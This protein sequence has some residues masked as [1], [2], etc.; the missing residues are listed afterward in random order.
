[1]NWLTQQWQY[2]LDH[3]PETLTPAQMAALDKA[4]GLTK[5]G[6]AEIVQSWL[7]LVIV[8]D[9]QPGMPRLEDYLATVGRIRLIL[10][11]YRQMM[12]TEA[13]AAAARRIYKKVRSNYHPFAASSVD[14]VV[15]LASDETSDEQ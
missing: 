11:L 2:F 9:Y 13:G 14:A 1:M 10:P 12:K 7:R 8:H 3:M 15:D 6:N 5:S 4:F